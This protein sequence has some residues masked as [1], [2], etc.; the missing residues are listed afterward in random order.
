MLGFYWL[1]SNLWECREIER[2]LPPLGGD[3][4]LTLPLL[5]SV[6]TFL[7]KGS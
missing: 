7:M 1:R 2:I 5:N 6:R 3:G 4:G